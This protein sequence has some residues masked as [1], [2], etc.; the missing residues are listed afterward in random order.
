MDVIDFILHKE[1]CT[2]HE[3]IKIA[4]RIISPLAPEGGTTKMTKQ[5]LSREQFLGNMYQYFK[6]AVSNSKPAQ[7]YLRLRTLDFRSTS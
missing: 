4:E 6:N 3:A 5:D 1:N 7:Q 2:K